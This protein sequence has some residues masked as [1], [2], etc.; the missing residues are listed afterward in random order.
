MLSCPGLS[1]DARRRAKRA[2]EVIVDD[3]IAFVGVTRAPEAAEA[4]DVHRESR[5]SEA[6]CRDEGV[7]E[8]GQDV[9]G[10]VAEKDLRKSLCGLRRW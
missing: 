6:A 1:A 3:C 8:E 10:S 4:A 9:D 5:M 7:R 2:R